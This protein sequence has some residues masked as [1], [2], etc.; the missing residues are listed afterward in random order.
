VKT[1]RQLWIVVMVGVLSSCGTPEG[2]S[3]SRSA[4]SAALAPP[5]VT[6]WIEQAPISPVSSYHLSDQPEPVV[7]PD[8]MMEKDIFIIN[9]DN[10]WNT[11]KDPIL[12][13]PH[14]KVI[15]RRTSTFNIKVTYDKNMVNMIDNADSMKSELG[16]T[17]SGEGDSSLIFEYVLNQSDKNLRAEVGIRVMK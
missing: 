17:M 13:Q 10:F 4:N 9:L 5:V 14:Q 12:V 16:F 15:I 6:P 1:K 8:T 3:G 7:L 11:K 2:P